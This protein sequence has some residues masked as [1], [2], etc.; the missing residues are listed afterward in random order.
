MRD[1][2][3]LHPSLVECFLPTVVAATAMLG[4]SGPAAG[5]PT[6][7]RTPPAVEQRSAQAR[8]P[9]RNEALRKTLVEMGREDQAEIEESFR[10]PN[11]PRTKTAQRQAVLRQILA[12]YGW[13]GI[14]LVG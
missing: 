1:R 7:T 13:P 10:N 3:R 2:N 8:K 4:S 14:S 5:A 6:A 12:E 11:P 9:A